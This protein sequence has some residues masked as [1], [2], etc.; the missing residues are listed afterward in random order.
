M[1]KAFLKMPPEIVLWAFYSLIFVSS[2]E[3]YIAFTMPKRVSWGDVKGIIFL[4]DQ[5]LSELE[6]TQPFIIMWACFRFSLVSSGD[7]GQLLL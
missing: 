3:D 7:A 6:E 1:V 4:F 5:L 2:S